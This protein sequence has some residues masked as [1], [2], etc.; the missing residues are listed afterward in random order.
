[1]IL[2]P[3]LLENASI[4]E[5]G[6]SS[7]YN[8][9]LNVSSKVNTLPEITKITL[10]DVNSLRLKSQAK[11]PELLK[12]E[13]ELQEA[14][15]RVYKEEHDSKRTNLPLLKI[16]KTKKS[17]GLF[18][19]KSTKNNEELMAESDKVFES[20]LQMRSQRMKMENELLT[21]SNFEI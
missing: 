15:H 13:I 9:D 1:L 14:I 17:Q 16:H 19:N 5:G 18:R 2:P 12:R 11:D 7:R 3:E 4:D 21:G 8:I 6:L 10:P 20:Y